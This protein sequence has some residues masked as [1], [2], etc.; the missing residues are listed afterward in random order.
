[1][2]EN[3]KRCCSNKLYPHDA[4]HSNCRAVLSEYLSLKTHPGQAKHLLKV[5]SEIAA[6]RRAIEGNEV[7]DPVVSANEKEC[8]QS[9]DKTC[10]KSQHA[11]RV[12]DGWRRRLEVL[13][14]NLV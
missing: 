4:S 9:S 12:I 3:I 8:E 2:H 13:Y 1:M 5:A 6:W 14:V 10:D 11:E 7:L